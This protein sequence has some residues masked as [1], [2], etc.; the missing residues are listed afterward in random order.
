MLR[1]ISYGKGISI[2]IVLFVHV[3]S[4]FFNSEM[5][6]MVVRSPAVPL[7]YPKLVRI[8]NKLTFDG[9]A[10]FIVVGAVCFFFL[11]TGYTIVRSVEQRKFLDFWRHKLIRLFPFYG[12]GYW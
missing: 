5:W 8:I 6:P 4:A 2:L 10:G 1:F 12:G 11:S 7:V 9:M 3:F